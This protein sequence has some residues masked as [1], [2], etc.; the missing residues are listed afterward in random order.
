MAKPPTYRIVEKIGEGGMGV[1][2]RAEDQVLHRDV[3][4]K[5]L[6]IDP[7]RKLSSEKIQE[8]Q[9]RFQREAQAAARLNHPNI[10]SV[11]Q[12]GS[13]GS[14]PYMVMEYLKGRSL[15]EVMDEE[16]PVTDVLKAMIQ[17]CGA[18]HYAHSQGVIHRDV[19]PD[20]IVLGEDGRVKITDFGIARVDE[21]DGLQTRTGVMLGSPAYCAPEQLK[22]F[23]HVDGRADIFSVGVVLYQWLTRRFPF[24]GDAATE[25]ISKILTNEPIPPRLLNPEIPPE[26]EAVILKALA[27]EPSQ[28]YQTAAE[29][30][31]ALEKVLRLL[32]RKGEVF[33]ERTQIILP[34]GRAHFQLPFLVAA[35]LL[36]GL[37]LYGVISLKGERGILEKTASLKGTNMARMLEVV[38]VADSSP[39]GLKILQG[40]LQAMGRERDTVFLEISRGD[41]TL[42]K[43]TDPARILEEGEIYVRGFP[44][45]TEGGEEA[46]LIVGFSKA[47]YNARVRQTWTV[48]IFGGVLLAAF[49]GFH[50][51]GAR[52]RRGG[53]RKS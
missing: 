44:L 53:K 9:R 36:V 37:L 16:T 42:A 6:R 11:Y 41:R 17:V 39:Q 13:S 43:F 7:E 50:L 35:L 46:L 31:V 18:L 27:K 34:P 28:R 3:A 33:T 21:P 19:K 15:V 26:L 47:A 22:D 20:N 30:Q 40:Y 25:I 45:R 49:V 8:I 38:G 4:I 52:A 24:E 10:V 14:Q 51:L 29:L 2:Y 12:V 1:V 5:V 32:Q 48:L 23:R